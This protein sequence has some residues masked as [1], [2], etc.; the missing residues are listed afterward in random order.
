MPPSNTAVKTA[1][2]SGPCGGK[3]SAQ[4]STCPV[5]R[6]CTQP[7]HRLRPVHAVA[8][9]DRDDPPRP[10]SLPSAAPNRGPRPAPEAACV[11]KGA[12]RPV[13]SPCVD[14]RR[15]RP[16]A[17]PS[18]RTRPA[19]G[20]GPHSP[21]PPRTPVRSGAGPSSRGTT[22]SASSPY[23]AAPRPWRPCTIP[24]TPPPAASWPRPA[25][26][27]RHQRSAGPQRIALAISGIRTRAGL[28]IRSTP[29][30][31]MGGV[32][33]PKATAPSPVTPPRS[34]D[35]HPLRP[36]RRHPHRLT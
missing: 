14:A 9:A 35:R 18:P 13:R 33:A 12:P 23:G 28:T 25:S 16:S 15:T 34:R 27:H 29:S 30:W 17:S 22:W 32:R 8:E 1:S 3:P 36:R 19:R 2:A 24:T 5:S 11:P 7:G 4:T 10:P 26:P 20:S 21:E 6:E 31:S